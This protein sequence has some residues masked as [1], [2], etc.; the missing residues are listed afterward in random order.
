V[1]RPSGVA[2]SVS[3]LAIAPTRPEAIYALASTYY[4]KA[5]ISH[6]SIYK[7]T[8][9]G[10]TWHATG[11]QGSVFTS[12]DGYGSALAV[13]PQR[14]T[15]L[16]AA[17][18]RAVVTSTDA[19]ESWQPITD[20]LPQGVVTALAVDPRHSGTVYAGLQTGR[21]TGGIYETTDGGRTWSRV[22]SAAIGTLAIDPA[23]SAT[24]YAAGWAGWNGTQITTFRIIRSTDSG[25]TWTVSG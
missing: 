19:G 6:T 16:Y 18:D 9:A 1:F 10:K 14:P 22:F 20:G 21:D 11:G 2:G 23:P 17:I 7:S 5:N 8:D 3:A 24:I 12:P 15:T 13:D 25:L 4:A